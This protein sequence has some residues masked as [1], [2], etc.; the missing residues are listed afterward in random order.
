M[1]LLGKNML[2]DSN[3]I[4]LKNI[5]KNFGNVKALKDVSMT[6]DSGK[7]NCILGDNGAGKSTLVNI[8]SGVFLSDKGEYRINNKTV[9]FL[10]PHEAISA[11]ISTVYQSLAIIP[12]MN[13]YR[14]FFLGN[15]PLNNEYFKI[16]DKDFAI[17]TTI[18][19]LKKFDINIENPKRLAG[20]LSGGERQL[21]AIARAL[22]FGASI[23]ILDEPTS[24]LGVKESNKVVEQIFLL[25]EQNINVIL[26]SHNIDQAFMLGDKFFIIKN[27][28]MV[29]HLDKFETSAKSLRTILEK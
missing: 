12:I 14:N 20:T 5:Y 6:T 22:Y 7:I 4:V 18:K 25:K 8:I 2:R 16:I 11:G 3:Q 15:E 27:G 1:V 29:G 13:I 19:E 23:L 26:V 28:E 9:E 24:A 21:L 10:N 17:E